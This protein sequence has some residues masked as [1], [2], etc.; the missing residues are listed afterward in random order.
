[1]ALNA[2]PPLPPLSPPAATA[3][4]GA[5][6]PIPGPG[7]AG[8]GGGSPFP[9]VDIPVK[10]SQ[11]LHIPLERAHMLATLPRGKWGEFTWAA[12]SGLVGAAPSG[13]E[14]L[15]TAFWGTSPQGLSWFGAVQVG[16]TVVFLTLFLTAIRQRIATQSSAAYL[17]WL[18]ALEGAPVPIKRKRWWAFWR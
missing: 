1:M 6:N 18:C 2:S 15:H 11:I 3:S 13:A 17:E 8:M 10:P 9:A 12:F 16:L 14:A 5:P 4:G 7:Q